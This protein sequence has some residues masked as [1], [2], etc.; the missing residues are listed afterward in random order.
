M[1]TLSRGSSDI[2]VKAILTGIGSELRRQVGLSKER[3][4]TFPAHFRKLTST[5]GVR[6]R[7]SLAK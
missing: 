6:D 7:A 3:W 4:A 2:G 1:T 5:P